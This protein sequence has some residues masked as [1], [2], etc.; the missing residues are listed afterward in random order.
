MKDSK[1]RSF[2]NM[3]KMNLFQSIISF[4]F[5]VLTCGIILVFYASAWDTLQLLIKGK[6][7]GYSSMV[8]LFSSIIGLDRFKSVIIILLASIYTSSFCED[9]N[10]RFLHMIVA[11]SSVRMYAWARL[12]ANACAILFSFLGSV[13]VFSISFSYLFHLPMVNH[14]EILQIISNFSPYE[15][16]VKNY[17]GIL[18]ILLITLIFGLSVVF[19]CTVGM[20]FTVYFPNKFVAIAMPFIAYYILCSLTLFFPEP[21]SFFGLSTGVKLIPLGALGNFLY[22]IGVLTGL[23]LLSCFY[24]E[25]I[26]EKRLENEIL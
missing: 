1:I 20:V 18:Y 26:L 25:I 14:K 5:I 9:W 22:T 16:I 11:R 2:F 17:P 15:N 10:S 24:F 12:T 19:L 8:S 6:F 13:L 3:M 7:S 4:K 23:W 21:L